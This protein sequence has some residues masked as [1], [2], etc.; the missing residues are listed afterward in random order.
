M[1]KFVTIGSVL[2]LGLG[3]LAGWA[4]T[5]EGKPFAPNVDPKTG[6]ISVPE[7]YR[8]W[9]TLGTWAHAKVEGA[10]GLQE[11]HVVYTQPDTIKYYKEKNRFP[12]GAVLV[13]ELLNADTMPMTTGPAVGHATT[14]KGWF[15]LVRDTTG[16]FKKSSLWGDGWGGWSL[17][18]PDDPQHTVSKDYKIDCL[19]CH[20][21]ARELARKNAVEADKWIYSF[22]YPVLQRK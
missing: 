18:N 6:D 20:T 15:V 8:E 22:G 4:M 7:N 2:I 9:P 10:P 19:P 14:I 11:Y 12:D 16:R 21:P 3:S 1:K 13:K 5:D 17:F